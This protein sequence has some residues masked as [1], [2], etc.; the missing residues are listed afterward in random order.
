MWPCA[1]LELNIDHCVYRQINIRKNLWRHND[2]VQTDIETVSWTL[3]GPLFSLDSGQPKNDVLTHKIINVPTTTMYMKTSSEKLWDERSTWRRP[4]F[5]TVIIMIVNTLTRAMLECC[6]IDQPK[7]HHHLA[8]KHTLI[9]SPITQE[10]D[11][12]SY[13]HHE[14]EH[15][16]LVLKLI[17]NINIFTAGKLT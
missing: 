16:Y 1:I 10:A 9:H 11:V 17:F 15:A 4:S 6:N 2:R 3:D 7:N 5:S 14:T 12:S 13:I 8:H